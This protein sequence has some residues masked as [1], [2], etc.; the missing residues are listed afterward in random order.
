MIGII[1]GIICLV[2][3]LVFIGLGIVVLVTRLL[4]SKVSIF[5]SLISNVFTFFLGKLSRK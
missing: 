4:N 2:L 3:G 5:V 1:L